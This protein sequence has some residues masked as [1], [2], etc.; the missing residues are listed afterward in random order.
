LRPDFGVPDGTPGRVE[1]T[2]IGRFTLPSQSPKYDGFPA[3]HILIRQ[4][5]N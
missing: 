5:G 1:T 4:V 3:E 2:Q